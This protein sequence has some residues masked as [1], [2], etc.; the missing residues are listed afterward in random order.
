MLRKTIYCYL[1][2]F[3]ELKGPVG[4]HSVGAPLAAAAQW[5][6]GLD[7]QAGFFAVCWDWGWDGWNVWGV[8]LGTSLSLHMPNFNCF[9]SGGLRVQIFY[10]VALIP[11]RDHSNRSKQEFLWPHLGSHTAIHLMYLLGNTVMGQLRFPEVEKFLPSTAVWNCSVQ[12]RKKLMTVFMERAYHTIM[13][14]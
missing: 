4:W 10:T 3:W 7:L 1:S 6:L 14:I 2:D 12:R 5:Q 11:Q 9:I 8:N 13:F